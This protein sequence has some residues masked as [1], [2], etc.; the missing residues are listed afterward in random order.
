MTDANTSSGNYGFQLVHDGQKTH[1]FS[2]SDHRAIKDW[3]KNLMKATITRDF[4]GQY[5]C[6]VC[7]DRQLTRLVQRPSFHLATSTRYP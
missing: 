6:R 4:T 2:S 1:H 5:P 3:M 7:I